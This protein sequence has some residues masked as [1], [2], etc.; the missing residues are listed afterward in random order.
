MANRKA[1]VRKDF[2]QKLAMAAVLLAVLLVNRCFF[3]KPPQHEHPTQ[4][5]T[6][7]PQVSAHIEDQVQAYAKPLDEA[8]AATDQMDLAVIPRPEKSYQ[9]EI[10]RVV[11]GDTFLVRWEGKRER[12]RLLNVDCPESFANEKRSTVIGEAISRAIKARIQPGT[13]TISFDKEQRDQYGRLL[14]MLWLDDQTTLNAKLI[15]AGY[16]TVVRFKPNL[17]YAKA[18][19]QLQKEAKRADRGLWA[20]R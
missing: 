14:A 6:D 16:A 2:L 12:L 18:L 11:D 8:W 5:A 15:A 19:D 3:Q 1:G 4:A 17:T 9:V 7:R 13:Y 20:E 10:L